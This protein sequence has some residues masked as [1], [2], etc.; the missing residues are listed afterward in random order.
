MCLSS[1]QTLPSY[2]MELHQDR[3][4]SWSS[5]NLSLC[6]GLKAPLVALGSMCRLQTAVEAQHNGWLQNPSIGIYFVIQD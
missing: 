5:L 1:M 6:I 2:T 4:L 3:I